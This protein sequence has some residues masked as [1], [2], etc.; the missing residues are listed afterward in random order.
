MIDYGLIYEII[1]RFVPPLYIEINVQNA[2]TAVGVT[3]LAIFEW[4][5]WRKHR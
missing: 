3:G 2:L 5:T 1:C 4:R